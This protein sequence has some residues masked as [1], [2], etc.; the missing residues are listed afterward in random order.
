M[1]KNNDSF[2]SCLEDFFRSLLKEVVT[3]ALQNQKT[4]EPTRYPERVNVSQAS[5]ITGYSKN[6]LYQ[7]HSKGTVPGAHKVGRKLMFY[8]ADL[9]A[10][11][12]NNNLSNN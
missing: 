9:E 12:H 11:I 2:G 7:M 3:E 5:E 10:W 1:N 6:S 8:T 4:E